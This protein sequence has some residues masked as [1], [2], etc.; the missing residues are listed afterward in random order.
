MSNYL[1]TSSDAVTALNTILERWKVNVPDSTWN[2]TGD[3]CSGWAI[4]DNKDLDNDRMFNPGIKCD[5]TYNSS[6]TCHII[7]L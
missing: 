4:D 5:C 3:P 2:T 7:K 1:F 6:K